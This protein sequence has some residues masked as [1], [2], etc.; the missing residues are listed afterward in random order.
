MADDGS[1]DER[2]DDRAKRSGGMG[3]FFASFANAM[4]ER[5]LP[6]IREWLK[7]RLGPRATLGKVEMDG[8]RIRVSDARVPLGARLVLEVER[9]TLLSN[10]EDFVAGLPPARLE[11][12]EGRLVAI[13]PG[14]REPVFVAPVTA[15]GNPK[16]SS[17]WVDADVDVREGTW[18]Q[19]R[20][21]GDAAPLRGHGHLRIGADGWVARDVTL[22]SGA[23]TVRARGRG[24]LSEGGV[25][26]I[27]VEADRARAGH[28]LDALVA[29]TGRELRVPPLLWHSQLDGEARI[30]PEGA[31]AKLTLQ[32]DTSHLEVELDADASGA[33]DR[34]VVRGRVGASELFRDDVWVLRERSAPIEVKARAS[35]PGDALRGSL[36]LRSDA[37]A[38]RLTPDPR[39]LTASLA[40]SDEDALG[41][42]ELDG[43]VSL[44]LESSIAPDGALDGRGAATL[45]LDAIELLGLRAGGDPVELAL[46][47]A[48]SRRAPSLSLAGTVDDA[49]LRPAHGAAIRV[50]R[51]RLRATV[52][53]DPSLHAEARL[54]R[55]WVQVELDRTTS[56][57]HAQRLDLGAVAALAGVG[58]LGPGGRF[59]W[60]ADAQL[61][62][63]LTR[64]GPLLRGDVHVETPGSRVSFR[65]L[66]LHAE[67]GLDGTT[68]DG[69]VDVDEATRAGLLPGLLTPSGPAKVSLAAQVRGPRAAPA[70]EAVLTARRLAWRLGGPRSVLPP[71]TTERARAAISIRR[72]AFEIREASAELFGGRLDAT[73]ILFTT[74]RTKVLGLTLAGLSEGLGSWLARAAPGEEALPDLA[75]DLSL[76][77][78]HG[79]FTGR[80][81]LRTARSSL[82][83][84]LGTDGAS[85]TDDT[86]VTGTV[87][88]ADLAALG[89]PLEG[90]SPLHVVMRVAGPTADPEAH[91]DLRLLDAVLS[92][93]GARV[94]IRSAHARATLSRRRL[95]WSQV[96][97]AL[98]DGA[99]RTRGVLGLS[100]SGFAGL[101]AD[102]TLDELA[103]GEV[104]L[105]DGP[106]SRW[107]DGRLSASAHL[108]GTR[109]LGARGRLRLE[110]PHYPGLDRLAPLLSRW[111]LPV[112]DAR[113]DAPL[114]ASFALDAEGFSVRDARSSV[115][116]IL[117]VGTLAL[118]EGRAEGEGELRIEGSWL[119]QS[120]LWRLP[121]RVLGD[122]RVPLSIED[123]DGMVRA[124]A[125]LWAAVSR[126]LDRFF[127]RGEEPA[128]PAPPEPHPE[129]ALG[130]ESL[131]TRAALGGPGA[132]D[133]L[134]VLLDRG[135]TP[136]EIARL[137]E[138]EKARE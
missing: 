43:A 68:V 138:R 34:L 137:I 126:A 17:A 53:P 124:R 101:A 109:T 119:A 75:L 96:E 63:D 89:V 123:V 2:D 127:G 38:T 106:L 40:I 110:D 76:E 95:V 9:A 13:D 55:G 86:A 112:P 24:S 10:P 74:S 59:D 99:L 44:R 80:A 6:A 51:G 70:F 21:V 37:L 108:Y 58:W 90:D 113:G 47:L 15:E 98:L 46:T 103:I 42:L 60:P 125:D 115:P 117:A 122:L 134:G 30:G 32:T 50:R 62:A 81:H 133:A 19:E 67:E 25:P 130:V 121:S 72:D 36:E 14:G 18:R 45:G 57:A 41:A 83:A 69:I 35:G 3:S 54:G 23:S 28:F 27:A 79:A 20:G 66:R 7:S 104:E 31:H 105:P 84:R 48:G 1:A 77:A 12:L 111:R 100:T 135:L 116:G 132:A 78:P 29:F 129:D 4:L 22:E 64:E 5:S 87:A 71:L 93:A 114:E 136:E 39:R 73:S 52:G 102:V 107:L 92:A 85:F 128:L 131:V 118:R 94:P 8:P 91:L 82:E 61:W 16:E 88:P 33:F 120:R 49:E 56:R 26:E 97:L 65:P 11:S